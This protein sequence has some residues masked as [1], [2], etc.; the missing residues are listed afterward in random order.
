MILFVDT[1]V[2]TWNNGNPFD[3]RNFLVCIGFD[4]DDGRRGILFAGEERST[5]ECLLREAT[6]VVFFNAK[7]DLH[8][9]RKCGYELPKRIWCCQVAEFCLNRQSPRYPSLDGTAASY[10]VPGKFD[11]IKLNYW[12]KG[13]NTDQIPRGE[14][15][16]YCLQDI[17]ATKDIYYKQLQRV[18]PQNKTLLSVQMQ[19]LQVLQEIEWNGLRFDPEVVKGKEQQLAQQI[20]EVQSKLDLFHAVPCFNWA[21]PAHVSA[22]LYGGS[23]V[24]EQRVPVGV[25]KSGEKVGQPRFQIVRVTHTLPR[26]YNPPKGSELAKPGTWS[27]DEDTLIK[28]KG[29]NPELI[30]GILKVKEL[31]KLQSTYVGGLLNK[32]MEMHWPANMLHGQY[33][34]VVTGTG[35]LS[36]T[37][38]NMQNIS[39]DILDQFVTRWA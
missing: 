5:F 35:R 11:Y 31:A 27:T 19:D 23:I 22:L 1:E 18:T 9:L 20:S 39:G 24:E 7:F 2:T 29:G 21:S 14:L 38:P 16:D 33:N 34:Q 10:G 28:I 36:S 8:W 4:S 37:N 12:D 26:M 32:H 15:T 25:Y 6:L 30:Q 3:E 13:I 17:T